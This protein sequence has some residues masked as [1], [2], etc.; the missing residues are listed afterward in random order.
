MF[1]VPVF[2]NQC[3]TVQCSHNSCLMVPF[4]DYGP[5]CIRSIFDGPVFV[6]SMLELEK[7]YSHINESRGKKETSTWAPQL[8]NS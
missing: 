4:S 6:Q 5:V 7:N 3:L 1:Y 8:A 2:V